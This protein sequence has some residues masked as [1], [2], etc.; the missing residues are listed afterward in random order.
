[1]F[2]MFLAVYTSSHNIAQHEALGEEK[3]F[4]SSVLIYYKSSINTGPVQE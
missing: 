1:M 4:F 2:T 3:E